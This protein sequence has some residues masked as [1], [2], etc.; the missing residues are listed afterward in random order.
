MGATQTESAQFRYGPQVPIPCPASLAP[1]NAGDI[2]D[3]GTFAGVA[4]EPINVNNDPGGSLIIM[5]VFSVLKATGVAI[6][7]GDT[8]LWDK[9]NK[10]AYVTGGGYTDDLELGPCVEPALAADAVVHVLLNPYAHTAAG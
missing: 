7:V 5:G 9:T 1:L 6:N 8:V 2:V 10:V 4:L 3:L